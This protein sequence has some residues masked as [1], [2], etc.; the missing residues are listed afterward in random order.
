MARSRPGISGTASSSPSVAP[1]S[2]VIGL[3][4]TLPTSL[5]QIWS[6]S[7]VST[8]ALSP[9]AAKA[10]E[11]CSQRGDRDPSGSPRVNRVPSM[12]RITP[13]STISVEQ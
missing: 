11:I 5:S 12:C 13:G 10:A 1:V 4:A 7:R 8:G 9:P 6:R 3:N 2:A